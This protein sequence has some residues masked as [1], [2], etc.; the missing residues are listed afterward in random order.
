MDAITNHINNA[1]PETRS[2]IA[3]SVNAFLEHLANNARS[4]F[5]EDGGQ[6]L[7]LNSRQRWGGKTRPLRDAWNSISFGGSLPSGDLASGLGTFLGWS[8]AVAGLLILLWIGWVK[9][10]PARGVLGSS[11]SRPVIWQYRAPRS[12]KDFVKQVDAFLMARF[13]RGASW[14]DVRRARAALDQAEERRVSQSALDELVAVY[15]S[16]R[17]RPREFAL[18]EN[19]L[20]RATDTLRELAAE[21][22][23]IP[24]APVRAPTAGGATA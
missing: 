1:S 21:L 10:A 9:L 17:Y 2:E 24:P 3:G 19:L 14:W 15:E 16:A 22:A 11:G 8:A 4:L 5:D 13:G 12:E 20:T 23:A 7:R 6:G 18:P